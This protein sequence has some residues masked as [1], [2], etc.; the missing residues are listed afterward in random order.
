MATLKMFVIH[1]WDFP[2]PLTGKAASSGKGLVQ[3][4]VAPRNGY[5]RGNVTEIYQPNLWPCRNASQ[6]SLRRM[7]VLSS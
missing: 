5:N 7:E 2:I 1:G 3:Q 6:P 4:L